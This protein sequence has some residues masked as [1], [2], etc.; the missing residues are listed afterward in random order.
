MVTSAP[1]DREDPATDADVDASVGRVA[2]RGARLV[3]LGQ[4]ARVVLQTASVVVLARLLGPSDFGLFAIVLALVTFGEAFRDFGLSSAAIQARV[5][6]RAQQSN[7]TWINVGLGVV[8]SIVCFLAAPLLAVATDEPGAVAVGRV[9]AVCFLINGAA[10]QYRADLNRRLKFGALAAT[11]TLSMA[12]GVV[13]GIVAAASG[14]GYWSLVLQQLVVLT[15]TLLLSAVLAGWL[16]R[17]PSSDGDVRPFLR[18]GAGMTGTQ[19]VGYFNNNVDT[20]TIGV[21]LGTGPLGVYNRAYQT[22]MN[23]LNQFRNPTTTVALPILA[24]LS[25]GTPE[26]DQAVLRGQAALGYTFV[27][28]TAFAAG[29]SGPIIAAALGP[30]WSEAAPLFAVLAVAGAFQTLGFTSYWIFLSR[31]LTGRL[32]GYSLATVLVRAVCVL[33][34]SHWGLLGVAIGYAFTDV[35]T[36]PVTYRLLARW[37]S[38]PVR[39]LYLGALRILSCGLA[40]GAATAAVTWATAHLPI[41]VQLLATASTT[42]GV[43]VLLAL[44]VPVVRRDVA[45]VVRFA[46]MA[47]GR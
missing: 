41:A 35:V 29:A 27:A 18:F 6:T 23:T 43:Y 17:R 42:L 22:L 2:A 15:S 7:L 4:M 39:G 36:F 47:L 46:R 8:L 31:A 38:L 10:G 45:G 16:P 37:T 12:G 40:A 28:G 21:A 19:L 20:L 5:L 33:A 32:F 11:D 13:V 44:A 9:M 14:L 30:R 26:A 24:R 3:V 1:R 25:A 34:G